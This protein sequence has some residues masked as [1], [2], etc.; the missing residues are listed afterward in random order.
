M[1]CSI[2]RKEDGTIIGSTHGCGCCSEYETLDA[3]ALVR[4]IVEKREELE[5]LRTLLVEELSDEKPIR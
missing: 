1:L 3:V 2:Y 4:V 5:K